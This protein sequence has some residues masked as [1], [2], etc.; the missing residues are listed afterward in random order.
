MICGLPR[1]FG[2]AV[3]LA[4]LAS[5]VHAQLDLRLET[6]K[7]AFLQYS[8]IPF[9][10]RMKN[11]GAGEL[12]LVSG[13]GR[14]WLEMVVQSTDGLV[15]RPERPW[16]VP[17]IR[18]QPGESRTFPIDLAPYYL[19]REP[20]GYQVRASV[21]LSSGE[22]LL[23]DPLTFLI[24]RGE[25]IWT[26][27][28]GEGADRRVYSLLKFFE[29]P[30]VGLYLRVEVPEKNLVYPSRRLGPYLPLSK[31]SAEFDEKSHLHILYATGAGMYR[32]TVVNQEGRVLRE[33]NR[34]EQG[35]RLSLTRSAQGEVEVKGGVVVLPSNLRERLSTL[36]ARAGAASPAPDA[37]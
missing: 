18:L 36:Q 1:F 32:L 15:I 8:P 21:R 17:E 11:L 31:P 13:P 22:T 3:L 37:P 6:G 12:H 2:V 19:V 28:R 14:P 33:E 30:A 4:G 34:Q 24:G 27:P 29:D 10:I 7:P 35:Q 25:V 9:Q 23:T 26:V 20:G 5:D 16:D